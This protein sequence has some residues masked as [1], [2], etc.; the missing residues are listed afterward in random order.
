MIKGISH[1]KVQ[2]R[3][4][5]WLGRVCMCACACVCVNDGVGVNAQQGAQTWD[6]LDWWHCHVRAVWSHPMEQL[7]WILHLWEF[8]I[9]EWPQCLRGSL[10]MRHSRMEEAVCV[11]LSLCLV[12]VHVS[13]R[14]PCNKPGPHMSASVRTHSVTETCSD[15]LPLWRQPGPRRCRPL[16]DWFG[17]PVSLPVCPQIGITYK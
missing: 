12:H 2:Q 3:F 1:D 11:R 7:L 6:P 10:V 4:F 5:H 16:N 13:P 17:P 8:G 15:H 9:S 14:S